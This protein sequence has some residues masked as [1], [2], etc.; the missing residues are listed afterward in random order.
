MKRIRALEA[1][2]K[3]L[4]QEMEALKKYTESK[5]TALES[6]VSTIREV[7]I[8]SRTFL[9]LEDKVLEDQ[10]ASRMKKLERW[11]LKVHIVR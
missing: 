7:L 10:P 3:K 6:E 5:T 4:L 1:E 11:K 9:R 8:S 2:N